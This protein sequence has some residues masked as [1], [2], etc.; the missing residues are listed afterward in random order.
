MR[1]HVWVHTYMQVASSSYVRQAFE[2]LEKDEK[3]SGNMFANNLSSTG[4]NKECTAVRK[5]KN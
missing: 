5:K 3:V 4:E 2:Q 1:K